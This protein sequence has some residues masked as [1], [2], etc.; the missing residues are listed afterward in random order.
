MSKSKPGKDFEKAVFAFVQTLDP[1]AEV[2][3]DHKVLDRDSDTWRQCDVWVNAKFQAHWPIS[4]LISCKDH[5]RKLDIGD[6]G[7]FCDEVR[8]TGASM[9]VIYSRTGFTGPALKKAKAN[10]LACCKLYRNQPPDIPAQIWFESY[11]C[12]PSVGLALISPDLGDEAATWN[13]IFDTSFVDEDG[14]V[15]DKLVEIYSEYEQKAVEKPR[16]TG[17]FPQDWA[18]DIAFHNDSEKNL[19]IRMQGLWRKYKARLAGSLI[20]GS[21]CLSNDSFF[22]SQSTPWIDM[23]GEH[24]GDGW[25]EMTDQNHAYASNQIL[26][27]VYQA[28]IQQTLR[29]KLGPKRIHQ[30]A[31]MADHP[32][33]L[34]D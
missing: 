3:F 27:I 23:K 17:K 20:N 24:P 32:P 19:V 13:E 8:S 33:E 5:T 12:Y 31:E 30:N 21:Y 10:G 18:F 34:G 1:S 26:A 11:A 16:R 22:G 9:G 6:I 4:I 25:I 28:N 2:I 14:T 7:T 15:L 29:E